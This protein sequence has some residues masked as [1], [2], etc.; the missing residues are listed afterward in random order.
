MA[1][2]PYATPF[3]VHPKPGYL[4]QAVQWT[5]ANDDQ[6]ATL[7]PVVGYDGDTLI[8]QGYE[9]KCGLQQGYWVVSIPYDNSTGCAVLVLSDDEFR[10]R[11][12]TTDPERTAQ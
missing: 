5:G 1:D 7:A 6:V 4:P 3:P 2:T 10:K 12:N 11:W 9:G 8:V